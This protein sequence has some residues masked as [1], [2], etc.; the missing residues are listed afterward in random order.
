MELIKKSAQEE[1]F[2]KHWDALVLCTSAGPR[3]MQSAIRNFI[4]MSTSR[5]LLQADESVIVIQ[6]NEPVGAVFLQ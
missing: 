4:E 6:N 2:W 5:A 3:Y 1:A